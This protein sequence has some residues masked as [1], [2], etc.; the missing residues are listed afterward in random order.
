[1]SSSGRV[2]AGLFARIYDPFLWLAE[3]RG[4]R[5]RRRE[6]LAQA[7]GLT[8]EIGGGTGLN[9]P[10]Y[11]R[12][13]ERLVVA[14]PDA[15]M[16]ARLEHRL[17]DLEQPAS[18]SDAVAERLPFPDGTVDTVVST[19]VLCTVDDPRLALREVGRVLAPHG[20]LLFIEHVR[21][22]SRA[23]ARLQ[24]RLEAP[25]CAFAGGCRCNRPTLTL[26]A[27]CGF[28]CDVSEAAWRGMPAIVKP[29]VYG[30]AEYVG[31]AK[32]QPE[33]QAGARRFPASSAGP[34]DSR[35]LAN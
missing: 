2:P 18:V 7:R 22:S 10:H 11:P 26:M 17:Q 34:R 16:R 25:W 33:V 8:L 30:R 4:L 9:L 19:L 20:Q 1:M 3:R 5:T 15:A 35:L 23:R 6:L 14:E 28:E 21:A 29:L 24:D 13:L 32:C 12:S 31:Q 27:E